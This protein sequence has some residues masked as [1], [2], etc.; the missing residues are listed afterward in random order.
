[1]KS[2]IKY[3]AESNELCRN[4]GMK[5]EELPV[6]SLILS[7]E[8]L[9]EKSNEFEEILSVVNFFSDKLLDLLKDI[10]LLIS[11]SDHEGFI[12]GVVGDEMIKQTISVLGIRPGIQMNLSTMGTNVVDLSLI[13]HQSPVQILGDEHYHQYLHGAACYG[14]AFKNIDTNKVLGSLSIMTFLDYQNPMI[15]TMLATIVDSIEREL[16]LRKKNK[17]ISILHQIMMDNNQYGVLTTNIDGTV[18]EFNI[19]A[20]I[21]MGKKAIDVIDESV[22]SLVPIGYYVMNVLNESEKY[23]GVQITINKGDEHKKIICLFDAFPIY[24]DKSKLIGAYAQLRDITEQFEVQERF[25]Y[26]ANHDDQTGLPNRRLLSTKLTGLV[27]REINKDKKCRFALLHLDLDR[28]KIVNDTLGHKD[29]D[30][31]LKRIADR[32]EKSL[33]EKDFIARVGGDEFIIISPF[34]EDDEV[35]AMGEK[36]RKGV[37]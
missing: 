34:N 35:V 33:N 21:L 31:V 4:A 12:L 20:E 5:S 16:L 37:Q 10:P 23:E 3:I 36:L 8:K 7:S 13:H 25:N 1:M 24:D 28:F 6:P 17:K 27:E 15:T 19:R 14:V 2:I 29:G 26:L 18:S 32:L 30:I 9:L 22:L 11:V